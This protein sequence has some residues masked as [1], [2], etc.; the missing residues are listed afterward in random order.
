MK[1]NKTKNIGI[2]LDGKTL[3]VTPT[4][5]KLGAKGKVLDTSE[6][7]RSLDK[8]QTRKIRKALRANGEGHKAGLS[9]I[10]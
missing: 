8:G 2:E 10:I 9:R 5:L 4:G 3:Y 1:T 6:L 7:Y